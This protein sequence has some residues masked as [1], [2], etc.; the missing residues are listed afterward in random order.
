MAEKKAHSKRQNAAQQDATRNDRQKGCPSGTSGTPYGSAHV[1]NAVA[2][3]L[4]ARS[5]K[6]ALGYVGAQAATGRAS[7]MAVHGYGSCFDWLPHDVRRGQVLSLVSPAPARMPPV[8][9]RMERRRIVSRS[10]LLSLAGGGGE[11][12]FHASLALLG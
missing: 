9:E 1:A 6:L 4:E 2:E 8:T 3:R 10:S 11:H 5:L 7:S 12:G